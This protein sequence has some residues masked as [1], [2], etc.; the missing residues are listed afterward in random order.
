VKYFSA[1]SFP[2]FLLYML[3]I[4]DEILLD[5]Q[6]DVVIVFWARCALAKIR[7]L[8]PIIGAAVGGGER[9]AAQFW[10]SLASIRKNTVGQNYSVDI[11]C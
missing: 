4:R 11:S 7:S 1:I 8:S 6:R 10:D 2:T 3:P 5:Q 9:A